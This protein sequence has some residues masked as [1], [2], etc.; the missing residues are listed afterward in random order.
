MDPFLDAR[1]QGFQGGFFFFFFLLFFFRSFLFLFCLFPADLVYSLHSNAVIKFLLRTRFSGNFVFVVGILK[2]NACPET[3]ERDKTR[4]GPVS[5]SPI[6]A[7]GP[8]VLDEI[9]PST[10]MPISI[11]EVH[12]QGCV[13]FT[14]DIAG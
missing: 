3:R 6:Q 12:T 11:G 9:S 4:R 1:L 2:K 5:N 7:K 14:V 13:L 8:S 10:F